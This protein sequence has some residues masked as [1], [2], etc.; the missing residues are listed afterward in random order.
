LAWTP[1]QKFLIFGQ[2]DKAARSLSVLWKVPVTGGQP[3]QMGISIPGRIKSPQIH[4]DGKRIFFSG[5]ERSPDELWA[6][7]NFLPIAGTRR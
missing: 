3:Q 5:I 2:G 1:D 7:E 6:L 4:P